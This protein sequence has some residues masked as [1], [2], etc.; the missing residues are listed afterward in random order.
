MEY[1]TGGDYMH[2]KRVYKDFETKDLDEYN[3]FY[4]KSDKILL[5]EV[6]ENFRKLCVKIDPV[7][8]L[9]ASGLGWEAALKK[10]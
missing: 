4:L 5:D 3:D 8:F 6:F 10:D 1:I 9:S 2:P 7:K